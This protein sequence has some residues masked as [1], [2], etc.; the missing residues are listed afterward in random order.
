MSTSQQKSQT[1]ILVRPEFDKLKVQLTKINEIALEI[2]QR[3]IRII[4]T[5]NVINSKLKSSIEDNINDVNV[6]NQT[7][8]RIKNLQ[9]RINQSKTRLT[10]IREKFLQLK[11]IYKN[12]K[13]QKNNI[14]NL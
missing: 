3:Q 9:D 5:A 8:Q 6:I 14:S 13:N 11:R 12:N 7:E 10:N 4:N 1:Q 2:Q